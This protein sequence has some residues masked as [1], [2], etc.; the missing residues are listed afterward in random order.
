MDRNIVENSIRGTKQ[1]TILPIGK[2]TLCILYSKFL[3]APRLF[4]SGLRKASTGAR[5]GSRWPKWCLFCD[6]ASKCAI[7]NNE[8]YFFNILHIQYCIS[9]RSKSLGSTW[10]SCAIYLAA[11]WGGSPCASGVAPSM[12]VARITKLHTP[13]REISSDS[14]ICAEY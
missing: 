10:L 14:A 3:C 6:I 2:H 7:R 13:G 4:P 5:D 12:A 11:I 1:Y 9:K 8:Y